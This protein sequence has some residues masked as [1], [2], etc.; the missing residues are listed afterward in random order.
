VVIKPPKKILT[1][2]QQGT[3][4]AAQQ[5]RPFWEQPTPVRVS[6]PSAFHHRDMGPPSRPSRVSPAT[7]YRRAFRA[8]ADVKAQLQIA[9]TMTPKRR[10]LYEKI[11]TPPEE[12]HASLWKAIKDTPA[13]IYHHSI[14][15]PAIR[16]LGL[17]TAHEAP[18]AYAWL[19]NPDAVRSF[20]TSPGRVGHAAR[21][22]A[23]QIGFDPK[24]LIHP[25]AKVHHDEAVQRR[26]AAWQRAHPHATTEEF[27]RANPDA[28]N[29]NIVPWAAPVSGLLKSAIET[30]VPRALAREAAANTLLRGPARNATHDLIDQAMIGRPPAEVR[31]VKG[32]LDARVHA[33]T[34]NL[35]LGARDTKKAISARFTDLGQQITDEAPNV[36]RARLAHQIIRQARE[37]V[38]PLSD[39]HAQSM[40]NLQEAQAAYDL[41]RE[42]AGAA[43]SGDLFKAKQDAA[44]VLGRA[45]NLELYD[46]VEG[47]IQPKPTLPSHPN[48][49]E[50]Q[51]L[52][53]SLIE[54]HGGTT[55][56]PASIQTT[57]DVHRVFS[58]LDAMAQRGIHGKEWYL[59][60]AKAILSLAR[61]DINQAERIAEL[62]AIYSPQQPILGNTSLAFRALNEHLLGRQ[63]TTGQE[64]QQK[65]AQKIL[66]GVGHWEGRKTNN[67]YRNF[68]A[69]IIKLKTSTPEEANALMKQYG[70]TGH[71]ITN[72]LWM[73][74][75]VGH[76]TDAVSGGRYDVLDA[77]IGQAAHE[78]GWQP[79]EVQAAIW[80]HLKDVS[81][82][83]SANIDFATSIDRHLAEVF[84]LGNIHPEL[85]TAINDFASEVG[86]LSR[87]ITSGGR[88][89]GIGTSAA[90]RGTKGAPAFRLKDNERRLLD[91]VT[92]TVAHALGEDSLTWVRPFKTTTPTR[93]DTIV[94]R[95]GQRGT[96][97]DAARLAE[98]LNPHGGERIQVFQHDDGLLVRNQD[99]NLPNSKPGKAADFWKLVEAHAGNLFGDNIDFAAYASDSRTVKG[100]NHV[101]HIARAFGNRA[102]SPAGLR[103]QQAADRLISTAESVRA[104]GAAGEPAAGGAYL[105]R[106]ER[107]PTLARR[108]VTEETG[109]FNLG[110]FL[111]PFGRKG[112]M[113]EEIAGPPPETPPPWQPPEGE[114]SRTLIDPTPGARVYEIRIGDEP[115]GTITREGKAWRITPAERF[116]QGT[117]KWPVDTTLKAAEQ[118]IVAHAYGLGP[119]RADVPSLLQGA[120]SMRGKVKAGRSIEAGQRSAAGER[121]YQEAGGGIEGHHAAKRALRG[122]Y[123]TLNYKGFQYFTREAL[124]QMV[125]DVREH[126]DLLPFERTRAAD[127]LEKAWEDAKLP[128]ESDIG[129]LERVFP[130]E[131]IKS[132][133]DQTRTKLQ[134]VGGAV[135]GIL[136]APRAIESSFD[137]SALLRQSLVASLRHPG[138][139]A[140]NTVPMVQSLFSKK[141]Y[142]QIME[143]IASRP[144]YNQM[145]ESGLSLLDIGK[146]MNRRE[147]LFT[148]RMAEVIPGVRRSE[149]AYTGFLNL[150]RADI[151]DQMA[152]HISDV[153][154]SKGRDPEKAIKN[155]A[156]LINAMT[157]RGGL[158]YGEKFAKELNVLFFSPRL[159]A[160]RI[161][162]FKYMVDPRVDPRVRLYAFRSML[163]TFSALTGILYL[164]KLN[165]ATVVTDPRN[166]DFGK[167][168][169]GNIRIDV[170]GGF[171]Q[172]ARLIAQEATQTRISSTTGKTYSL[173][174][175]AYGGQTPLGI[176][177]SFARTKLAP[178]PSL[179][180]DIGL[181]KTYAGQPVILYGHGGISPYLPSTNSEL[182]QRAM[183]LLWQ[184]MW[185]AYQNH[186][187]AAEILSLYGLGLTGVGVQAYGKK[188][189]KS[190]RS[191]IGGGGGSDVGGADVGIGG[192]DIGGGP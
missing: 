186:A 6:P 25:V 111:D 58:L 82:D 21:V 132:I 77:L 177:F 159:F 78:R 109:S 86:L 35:G 133:E 180:A 52:A 129:L 171:Q 1:A 156:G 176:G 120:R 3:I 149:R 39:A 88:Q 29:A 51:A 192:A 20:V 85:R 168:K 123:M 24:A 191:Y 56:L 79:R 36:P 148:S 115:V 185:D 87:E 190:R 166:P 116:A 136:N 80:T 40:K 31:R 5:E 96:H 155:L 179:L 184:D 74:R 141:A 170:M 46:R 158:S 163:Q 125:R 23:M 174:N 105:P 103:F 146:D 45:K 165:G 126:P 69:D 121:A 124:D 65:A 157:G 90:P 154:L 60:S 108:L 68:M 2:R 119:T 178:I 43:K 55:A 59:N 34:K 187:N 37:A 30:Q 114:P 138:L 122:P 47:M 75:S 18:R 10:A 48:Y 131:V 41:A 150:M 153:A 169:F 145:M 102:G 9:R 19:S 32:A 95:L 64:W 50:R 7:Q 128:S 110:A 71:E 70:I 12:V 140:K 8:P 167:I 53:E 139:A 100:A 81:D 26:L 151:F 142:A 99:P 182:Y 112:A 57:E 117:E 144:N 13:S 67:F 14:I 162:M 143:D 22:A 17:L 72:D 44:T 130:P 42:K 104:G 84:G 33:E 189:P 113:P 62:F 107:I 152:P 61:G 181:R 63:I 66:D 16:G 160:S 118:R 93:A 134:K 175:P 164:A 15:G 127:A 97:G 172:M 54:Q 101:Q 49:A 89:L 28:L 173:A 92:S 161:A 147:E 106:I 135:S 11:M 98:Q 4:W 76:T 183:P 188:P 94:V 91:A 137:V 27:L 38:T 73:S 83:V